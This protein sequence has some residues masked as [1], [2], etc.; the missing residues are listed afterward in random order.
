VQQPIV[1]NCILLRITYY[2]IKNFYS[3]NLLIITKCL[4]ACLF[5]GALSPGYSLSAQTNIV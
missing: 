1:I 3:H 5:A 2:E 4:L